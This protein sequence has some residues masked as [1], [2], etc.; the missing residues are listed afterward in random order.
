M[1]PALGVRA[2]CCWR[3]GGGGEGALP[4][5]DQC[6]ERCGHI[7]IGKSPGSPSL[8]LTPR[9]TVASGEVHLLA[10]A[11]S[12]PVNQQVGCRGPEFG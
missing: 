9:N 5:R 6:P 3:L 4:R 8:P 1:S 7:S 10:S 2:K 11:A 12:S